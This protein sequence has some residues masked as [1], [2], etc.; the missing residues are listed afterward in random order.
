V[1]QHC[2]T[3]GRKKQPICVETFLFFSGLF[4][5]GGQIAPLLL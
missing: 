3:A 1:L 5:N 4:L 2:T